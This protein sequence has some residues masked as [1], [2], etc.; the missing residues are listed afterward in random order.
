M[1]KT[2]KTITQLNTQSPTAAQ[3]AV[4]QK[5]AVLIRRADFDDLSKN[6]GLLAEAQAVNAAAVAAFGPDEARALFT[7]LGSA[8]K[9]KSAYGQSAR[10]DGACECNDFWNYC[11]DRRHCEKGLNNCTEASSGCGFLWVWSC[12]GNCKDDGSN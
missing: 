3:L 6:A 12:N 2:D 11:G 4:F 8:V 1:R 7:E 10:F 5:V 9:L